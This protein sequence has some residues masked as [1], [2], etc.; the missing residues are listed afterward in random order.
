MLKAELQSDKIKE[1]CRK[2]G[3]NCV[4]FLHFSYKTASRYRR[5]A[6]VLGICFLAL[7]TAA[8]GRWIFPADQVQGGELR[9]ESQQDRDALIE[10]QEQAKKDAAELESARQELLDSLDSMDSQ[11]VDV[12]NEVNELSGEIALTETAIAEAEEALA[13][14][15]EDARAQYDSM[16]LR[17]Q[18][19][20]ENGGTLSWTDI[21]SA[22][23]F[24]D[25]L[26]RVE[27]ATDLATTDR[28]LFKQYEET[29]QQLERD[30]QT[31][32]EKRAELLQANEQL[33]EKKSSLLASIGTAQSGVEE[34][35][36]QL[37]EKDAVLA[38]IADQLTAMEEYERRL[39]EQKAKEAAEEQERIRA[40]EE[41]LR[42]EEEE[43]QKAEE[44]EARKKAEEEAARQEESSSADGENAET[45][46]EESGNTENENVENGNAEDTAAPDGTSQTD[47]DSAVS[48][49][50]PLR[51]YLHTTTPVSVSAEEEELFAALVYCEAGGESYE[52]QLAVASVVV[53]RINSSRYPN[54]LVDVIY[55][56]NQF[57]PASSG[58]L[59]V[60]LEKGLTTES[61]RTAAREALAGNICGDWLNFCYNFGTIDGLV[62][63]TEVFYEV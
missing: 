20:Y 52:T 21:F 43:R 4:I 63:G 57:S 11:L 54:S 27:Y 6:V 8:A 45:G 18:Y 10:Q 23:S 31:L 49:D 15:E 12:S 56:K 2:K 48:A 50:S 51:Y 55:Q 19:M 39:E 36:A 44:E 47:S 17:I 1:K 53:N 60:V 24:A 41:R 16:K 40:E 42:Q 30:R 33:G 62:I 29:L 46:N 3:G 34:A 59:A 58:R 7:G 28:R 26:S 5:A 37:A 22:K 9:D 38:D 61:C 14:T 35:D 25:A 13:A 32:E